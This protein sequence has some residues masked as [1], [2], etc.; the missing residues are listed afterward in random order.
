MPVLNRNQETTIET[1]LGLQL[2]QILIGQMNAA[3]QGP[4][5]PPGPP[6][7]NHAQ[8]TYV[9]D[10]DYSETIDGALV[11][12]LTIAEVQAFWETTMTLAPKHVH[13][14]RDEGITHPID[15]G[16]F[17]GKEFEMVI[18]S[19]KGRQAA[20]PGLAQILLKQACD[21]FQF[22]LA[23]DRKMKNQYLTRDSIKSHAIQFQAFKDTD[24]KEI[25]GLPKLTDSTDVLSWLDSMEKQLQKLP[26]VDYSPLAYLLRENEVAEATTIDLLP[27]R[28]YSVTH[29]SMTGELIARKSQ[30]DTCAETD[31]VTLYGYLVPALENGPLESA[32]QPHEETKDGQAVVRTILLQHGGRNKWETAHDQ[33]LKDVKTKWSSANGVKT[34]TL[35]IGAYRQRVVDL[36]KCCKHTGRSPPTVREQVLWMIGSIDTTDPLLIAHIAQ[37]NGDPLGMGMDFKRAATHLMLADPV[38]RS[39]VKSKRKRSGNPSILALAGRGET[40]VDFRWHNRNEF[41]A[42]SSNQK[43]ELSAWRNTASGK[44]AMEEAKATFKAKRDAKKQKQEGGGGNT[45][46]GDDKAKKEKEDILNNKKLQKKFQVAVAKASKKMVAASIEAEKA[47]VAA[48]DL[49]LE[50]AIKRRSGTPIISATS[51]K[52]DVDENDEKK[53]TAQQTI[54]KLAAV[55]T[56]LNKMSKKEV[57]FRG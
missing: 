29:S 47:E 31:K 26:G 16:L 49:S 54:I 52:E 9:A 35:H 1:A 33:V 39:A 21:Y 25:G 4:P 3:A 45:G 42:L 13:A 57:T 41:K 5:V 44:K 17:T 36:K 27:N 56:R 2:G 7:V 53:F 28:C 15:S 23:T 37:I 20:L 34:L 8:P 14:L 10:T 46:S 51:V 40:G 32:L 38:A 6:L 12:Y 24:S 18:R 19:M 50:A 22:L 55:K 30:R 11:T 48:A 43:D